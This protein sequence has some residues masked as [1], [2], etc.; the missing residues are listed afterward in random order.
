MGALGVVTVLIVAVVA[1][2]ALS[3]GGGST[4]HDR[5]PYGY[6]VQM[7]EAL[8]RRHFPPGQTYDLYNSNPPTSGP[9]AS[10][11]ASWGVSDTP[12]PK[13]TAVHNMEHAGVVVWYNCAAGQAP[14]STAECAQLRNG[15]A[16]VVQPAVAGGRYVLMT[17]YA[18]MDYRIAL[19]AW[20]YMDTFDELDTA[21]VEAFIT[22]F[23]CKTD[24]ERLCG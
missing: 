14:L 8:A 17:P 11:P 23:E 22:S 4:T 1:L 12:V 20:Q 3:D 19:T 5:P 24:L 2:S 18:D 9:H 13:E 6:P 21:R 7:F 16:S 10:V 15:L